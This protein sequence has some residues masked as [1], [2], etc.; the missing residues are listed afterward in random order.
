MKSKLYLSFA[1]LLF[2]FLLFFCTTKTPTD[3]TK[4]AFIPKPVSITATGDAFTVK[5]STV[6]FVESETEQVGKYLSDKLNDVSGYNLNVEKADKN[7]SKG[8]FLTLNDELE[9]LGEEGYDLIIEKKLITITAKT[10]AGCFNGIQT[11]LQT[12]PVSVVAGDEIS[13]AT[14]KIHDFP[15]SQILRGLLTPERRRTPTP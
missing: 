1:C 6:I 7:P 4:T 8:I 15:E 11:L 12:L 10:P 13:I 9:E 3:L 14:G 5:T 2:L